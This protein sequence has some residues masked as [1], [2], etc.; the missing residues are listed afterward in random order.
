MLIHPPDS[1]RSILEHF[2]YEP[3]DST[4][5]THIKTAL[6]RVYGNEAELRIKLDYDY[7][8][9]LFVRFEFESEEE[10]VIFKLKHGW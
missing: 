6:E 5:L 2:L 4:T 9:Y 10:A 3:A 8:G 7:H 1:V